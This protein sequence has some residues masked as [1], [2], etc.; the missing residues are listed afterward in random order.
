MPRLSLG[1]GVQSVRKIKSG[2]AAPSGI[3]VA[4]TVSIIITGNVSYLGTYTRVSQ[5]N[6]I[7]N[8]NSGEADYLVFNGGTY[9][10]RKPNQTFGQF[11][12]TAT[13]LFAP[14]SIVKDGGGAGSNTVGTPYGY[15]A[16][17]GIAYDGE[18]WYASVYGTNA[19]TDSTII[20]TSGW[21]GGVTIT[22]A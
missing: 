2:G 7:T 1:L 20:P 16:L 4:S 9:L 14:N 18:F 12:F 3:P 21:T 6:D 15:W 17:A 10:Y 5:P 8:Q 22:A 11:D 19:S 13:I